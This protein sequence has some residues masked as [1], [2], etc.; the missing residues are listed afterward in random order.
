MSSTSPGDDE[1]DGRFSC[2]LSGQPA[3]VVRAGGLYMPYILMPTLLDTPFAELIMTIALC[4]STSLMIVSRVVCKDLW[5]RKANDPASQTLRD[6]AGVS[7]DPL[8]SAG[9]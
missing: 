3:A 6:D 1:D 9:K 5:L 7:S 4:A 8:P 2:V